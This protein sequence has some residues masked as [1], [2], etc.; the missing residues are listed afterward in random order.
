MIA[1]TDGGVGERAY[2]SATQRCQ[3][4]AMQLGQILKMGDASIFREATTQKKPPKG[5]LQIYLFINRY[6]LL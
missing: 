6:L 2:K 1:Y 5:G 3:I 4:V